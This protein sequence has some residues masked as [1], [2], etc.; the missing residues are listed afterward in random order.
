[1]SYSEYTVEDFIEDPLFIKWVLS[2]NSEQNLYWENWLLDHPDKLEDVR[3]SREIILA[4]QYKNYPRD[5]NRKRKTWEAIERT[6]DNNDNSFEEK[7]G[8]FPD[9]DQQVKPAHKTSFRFFVK[10]AAVFVG[11]LLMSIVV[12]NQTDE[13]PK[14]KKE[15]LSIVNEINPKGQRS[16][17]SLPDGSTVY[18]NAE[19]ALSYSSEFSTDKREIVLTGEAFFEVAKDSLRPFVVV[20]DKLITTA[21]GTSFNVK[22]YPEDQEILISL[23][24]GKV[25]VHKQISLEPVLFL[26]SREA[27]GLNREEGIL[28]QKE[29]NYERAILWKDGILYFKETPLEEAFKKLEKWYGVSFNLQNHPRSPI[30]VTG[31]FD[32]EN[33]NNVL[34]SLSY[35]SNFIYSI[36][37]K[38]VI[39][40]FK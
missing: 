4:F 28:M 16:K 34:L 20:A 38:N 11:I 14:L 10:L 33:L 7:S 25:S 22:A 30:V 23:L 35:T 37:N 15:S 12:I 5:E 13:L 17:I 27:A 2:P 9:H 18:L 19:S 40:S 21:L 8:V 6:N 29:F 39:V 36:E 24:S 26:S 1:M 32:N 31:E 3:R